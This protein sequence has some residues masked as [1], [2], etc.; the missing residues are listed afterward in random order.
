MVDP[1]TVRL[2]S[3]RA[4]FLG[5]A[6]L[7]SFF[8]LLPLRVGSGHWPGPDLILAFAFAWV[9][10][11]PDYVPVFLVALVMLI[12]DFIFLRPPG[13]WAA[14]TVVALEFLRG[15]EPTSRDM[16]FAVE[17]AMVGAV[18]LAMA[19]MYRLC[20]AIFMVDQTS[21][22]LAILGQMSTL[23]S[24]PVVVAL[25]HYGLGIAKISPSEADEMRYVR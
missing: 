1:R 20:L 13:L 23:L 7:A 12:A 4:G 17:W 10:R 8:Y 15:R 11:R 5:I 24:Y 19:L 3:F 6:I 21:L 2:W 9:M 14:L 16:P 25:S 18:M 22:G